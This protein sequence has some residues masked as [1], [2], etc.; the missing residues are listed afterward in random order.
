MKQN[1]IKVNAVLNIIYTVTNMLFPIITFPYV[2]RALSATGIGKVSFYTSVS[3]YAIMLSALGISTYGIRAVARTRN[4][5]TELAK[6]VKELLSINVIATVVVLVVYT[7]MVVFIPKFRSEYWLGLINGVIILT[8]PLGMNWLYSG[9]E[10]YDYITK[11]TIVFKLISLALVFILIHRRSDYIVYACILA[12]SNI[13]TYVCNYLFSRRLIVPGKYKLELAKHLKSMFILFA[14]TLAVN[15]YINLDTVML[16][17]LRTDREVGLYTTAVKVKVVLLQIVNAISTVLL[18]RL[19]SYLSQRKLDEYNQA[20][21]KSFSLIFSITIP[22]TVYFV[23][24]AKDCIFILGGEEYL[25]ATLCM[26]ILMPILIISGFSNVTG[27]QILIPN[28]NDMAFMKAVSTGAI[29]DF[30]LNIILMSNYGFVGAAIATLFAEICQMTIQVMYSKEKVFENTKVQMI[31]R[32]ILCSVIASFPLILVCQFLG[33]GLVRLVITSVCF[34]AV[35][36]L[37]CIVLGDAFIKEIAI[38]MFAKMKR[39]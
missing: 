19:S 17:V 11:R 33:N 14:S 27:N 25:E 30:I 38:S 12:L 35:Y 23:L 36:L 1:S 28:G 22:L 3:N 39:R 37:L 34:F 21:K 31:L 8:A 16:G 32:P 29:V 26:Q 24:M 13:G 9:L 5:P 20:L 7:G 10:Q 18:P 6:T 15:V 4:D 2:S